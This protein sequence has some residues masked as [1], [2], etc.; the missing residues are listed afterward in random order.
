[1]RVS[2][3]QL[4]RA[5][6]D[7]TESV[8]PVSFFYPSSSHPTMTSLI[9]PSLPPDS[10]QVGQ[11]C[12]ACAHMMQSWLNR[13][14]TAVMIVLDW[15]KPWDMVSRG[16][17]LLQGGMLKGTLIG[18]QVRELLTWLKWIASWAESSLKPGQAD[19]MREKCKI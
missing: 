17:H 11:F 16:L 2:G 19:E 4:G 15:T 13:Q 1:M 9:G 12:T 14:D 8:P 6:A 3:E 5:C 18:Q 10:I 7:C